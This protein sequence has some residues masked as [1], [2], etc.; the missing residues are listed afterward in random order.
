MTQLIC[1]NVTT[2]FRI[3]HTKRLIFHLNSEYQKEHI[4]L[5]CR[6]LIQSRQLQ[7]HALYTCIQTIRKTISWIMYSVVTSFINFIQDCA[8]LYAKFV[9]KTPLKSRRRNRTPW[10]S[11]SCTDLRNSVKQYEKLVNQYLF[12]SQYRKHID[13]NT[14][15]FANMQKSYTQKI[16]VMKLITA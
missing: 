2:A 15:H 10:F 7:C 6:I 12:N 5:L 9:M 3:S 1:T 13:Q 14:C 8:K 4:G 11:E 16:F